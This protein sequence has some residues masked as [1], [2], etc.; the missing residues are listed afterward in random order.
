MDTQKNY[1]LHEAIEQMFDF[2]DYTPEKKEAM[3]AETSGMVMEGT[4]LRLL[5]DADEA[6]QQKFADFVDTKPDEDGMIEFI[7]ANFPA[8]SEVM[9]DELRILK[10]LGEESEDTE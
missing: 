2:E 1:T 9:I 5:S 4:I 7:Q 3:I 10:S 8:F 6:M